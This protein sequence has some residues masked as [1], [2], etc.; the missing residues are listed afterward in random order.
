VV[1]L[2]GT[3]FPTTIDSVRVGTGRLGSLARVSG[4]QLTGITPPGSAAGAVD[5]VVYTT[6]AGDATCTGCFTYS[7]NPSLTAGTAHT[8]GL[9]SGGTACCWGANDH[10]QL[11]D[12]S[13]TNRLTPVAAAGGLAFASLTARGHHT[14]GLRSKRRDG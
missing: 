4:T 7:S 11:G 14:C 10:G 12:G 2:T 9:T 3:N 8:C 6:S 13:T 1:T 5:V